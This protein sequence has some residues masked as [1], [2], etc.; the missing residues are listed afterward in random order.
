MTLGSKGA[1]GF[2]TEDGAFSLKRPGLVNA[3]DTVG[4]QLAIVSWEHY[5]VLAQE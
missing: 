4:W 5:F 2:T 1:V 3:V